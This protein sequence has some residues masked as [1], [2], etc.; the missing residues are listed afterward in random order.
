[1]ISPQPAKFLLSYWFGRKMDLDQLVES[2]PS[3]PMLFADSGAFSAWTKGAVIDR[4]DYLAWLKRW[5]HLITTAVNLDVI[6]DVDATHANQQYLERS[7]VNVIPVFHT[8]TPMPVLDKLA[9][10]YPY[11]GLGGMVGGSVSANHR[12]A[13]ACM[14]RT[15]DHGTA[16]HAFGMTHPKVLRTLPWYSADSTTWCNGHRYGLMPVWTGREFVQVKVCKPESVYPQA[17]HIRRYG[18]DPACIADRA[19]YSRDY[20]IQIAAASWHDYEAR[21][22]QI[23][24][25]IRCA[26]RVDGVHIYLVG[27]LYQDIQLAAQAIGRQ[28]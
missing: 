14:K 28:Q 15:Q 26:D 16:F 11:I 3:K 4:K 10:H 24:G 6:R 22:R 2:M 9:A 27:T 23:H 21:L 7:G 5:Q 25:P 13:A 20:P 12:W 19:K 8:G 1:M 17:R 18:I